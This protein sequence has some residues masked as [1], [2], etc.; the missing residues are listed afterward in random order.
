MR[1]IFGFKILFSVLTLFIFAAKPAFSG[2]NLPKAIWTANLVNSFDLSLSGYTESYFGL[3]YDWDDDALWV[4]IPP[5]NLIFQIDK[6]NGTLLQQPI[7]YSAGAGGIAFGGGNKLYITDNVS[8][9]IWKID[10]STGNSSVYRSVLDVAGGGL[11][12]DIVNDALFCGNPDLYRYAQYAKPSQTGTLLFWQHWYHWSDYYPVGFGCSFDSSTA[13]DKIFT[14]MHPATSTPE[15]GLIEWFGNIDGKPGER[16]ISYN[17]PNWMEKPGDC[18]FDGRYVY[19][20]ET[21]THPDKIAVLDVFTPPAPRYLTANSTSYQSVD[22]SW[23][24]VPRE[25]GYHIYRKDEPNEPFAEIEESPVGA[26]VTY[27]RDDN[28]GKSAHIYYYRIKAYNSWGE[29]NFTATQETTLIKMPPI[30]SVNLLLATTKI[31]WSNFWGP[32]GLDSVI[33]YQSGP[34][35]PNPSHTFYRDG[36]K[37]SNFYELFWIDDDGYPPPGY[38]VGYFAYFYTKRHTEWNPLCT[39][40]TYKQ[41]PGPDPPIVATADTFATAY[42]NSRKIIVDSNDRI[43]ITYTSNDTVYYIYSDDD[44]ETYSKPVAVGNG[45]YPGLALDGN[46]TPHICW[47]RKL[48][49]Y[50]YTLYHSKLTQ[51]GW[52]SPV[53]LL[54]EYKHTSTPASFDIDRAENVAHLSW[55]DFPLGGDKWLIYKGDFSLLDTT[56]QVVPIPYDSAVQMSPESPNYLCDQTGKTVEGYLLWDKNG[57]IYT[58]VEENGVVQG[59]TNLSNSINPSTHPNLSIFGDSVYAVWQENYPFGN[60]IFFTRRS[61]ELNSNWETPVEMM[62]FP[63]SV[64]FPVSFGPYIFASGKTPEGNFDIYGLR[65]D[66]F[67]DIDYIFQTTGTKSKSEFPAIC[68][69]QHFPKQ[70]LYILWTEDTTKIK[71]EPA[72][73]PVKNKIEAMPPAIPKIAANLGAP[74]ASPYT[75]QREGYKVFGN[76]AYQKVDYDSKKLIYRFT[77]LKPNE[78]YKL[79]LVFY[80][81]KEDDSDKHLKQQI[82]MVKAGRIPIGI[83]ILKPDRIKYFER[84]IPKWVYESGNLRISIKKMKGEYAVCSEIF[85]YEYEKSTGKGGTQFANGLDN[86]LP[87]IQFLSPKPNPFN[88]STRISFVIP[89]KERVSLRIYDASGRLCRTLVNEKL[90]AGFHNYKWDGRGKNGK[91]LSN[92]VYF[93]IL[94]IG[95][96]RFVKKMIKVK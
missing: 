43:H 61:K 29:S 65:T 34:S 71:G 95:E 38:W 17:L 91:Q 26:N 28:L 51:S 67:G 84:W 90:N 5:S 20:I 53:Q 63:D 73:G 14:V 40:V 80:N 37:D 13:S 42:S 36:K 3:T 59:I 10:L 76:L 60:K 74:D 48:D 81:K 15:P 78:R 56:P 16:V 77:G 9:L 82:L 7:L 39:P 62:F 57:D 85:L 75:V 54:T 19:V 12:W 52:S 64:E 21:S 93:S 1:R 46:E 4:N 11:G 35:Y 23:D 49:N 58:G 94:N 79:K 92:G 27:V 30:I 32:Y 89:I 55:A 45:R 25:N 18:A 68:Y 88:S 41:R 70:K 44:G 6:G 47:T 87:R 66:E 33:F 72:V 22:L 83:V 96:Q 2:E 69:T 86:S 24:N 31:S 8:E 50:G